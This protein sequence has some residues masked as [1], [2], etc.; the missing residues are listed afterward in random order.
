MEFTQ[1]ELLALASHDMEQGRLEGALYKLK[2]VVQHEAAPV[3]GVAMAAKLYAQL[4]LFGSAKA[5][6]ERYLA[7]DPQSAE[8]SFE[9][10]MVHFDMGDVEAAL[11]IWGKVLDF[12]PTFPPA[13]F[14]S[15]LALSNGKHLA[16]AKRHLDVLLQTAPE[17]NLYFSRSKELLQAIEAQAIQQSNASASPVV[18]L[19][20]M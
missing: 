7:L 10:G 13:L 20:G 8:I 14:Y 6:Y 4:R 12:A 19:G 2:Q 5:L 17:D 1:E 16:D 11:I 3:Y 18:S 9:L 15:A